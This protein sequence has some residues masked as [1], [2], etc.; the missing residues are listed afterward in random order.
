MWGLRRWLFCLHGLK[1][2]W[3]E[4]G[5]EGWV[6]GGGGE[7]G[8]QGL[9]EGRGGDEEGVVVGGLD[10]VSGREGGIGVVSGG[11]GGWGSAGWR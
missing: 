3:E 8:G 7:V 9:V 10:G 4:R 5:G 11:C 6:G 2:W 1:R